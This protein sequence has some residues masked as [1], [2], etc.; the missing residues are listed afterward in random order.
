MIKIWHMMIKIRY[1]SYHGIVK[2]KYS[3]GMGSMG[4]G[5]VSSAA[6]YIDI[7]GYVD[8]A[9]Y[10]FPKRLTSSLIPWN[11]FLPPSQDSFPPGDNFSL[12]VFFFFFTPPQQFSIECNIYLNIPVPSH[13]R[14]YHHVLEH[15]HSNDFRLHPDVFSSPAIPR[16]NLNSRQCKPIFSENILCGSFTIAVLEWFARCFFQEI[17]IYQQ[18]NEWWRNMSVDN[19]QKPSECNLP[20]QINVK[21]VK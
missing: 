20:W 4:T 17:Y 11:I 7:S 12:P 15:F 21:A 10:R 2:T 16:V 3:P 14:L 5:S 1:D 9:P 8:S 6:S 13:S 18:R 19:G